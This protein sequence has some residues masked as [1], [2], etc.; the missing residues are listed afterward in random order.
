RVLHEHD[1]GTLFTPTWAPDGDRVAYV[2]AGA[3]APPDHDPQQP[4]RPAL[5]VAGERVT[6]DE[7]VYPFG[8][9]WL[10]VSTLL[11]PASGQ[12]CPRPQSRGEVAAVPFSAALGFDRHAYTPKR[13]NYLNRTR[14]PVKGIANPVLSPDGTTAAFVALN[15][16]WTLDV[17]RGSGQPVALTDD[18]YY[19]ATPFWSPDGSQLAYSSD[20]DGPMAI[21][22]RDMASG[23]ERKL[24]GDFPL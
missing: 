23:Q 14:H 21:Y 20:R 2:W 6:G 5:M 22:L 13:R 12:S 10:D 15:Q 9:Q 4:V 7:D 18:V 8:A 3:P 17:G 11:H 24:T 1:R 16:L 19:K